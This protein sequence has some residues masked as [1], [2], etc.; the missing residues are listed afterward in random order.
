[1]LTY[2]FRRVSHGKRQHVLLMNTCLSS[3][4]QGI[5]RS[6]WQRAC[7]IKMHERVRKYVERLGKDAGSAAGSSDV[8]ALSDTEAMPGGV[9]DTEGPNRQGSGGGGGR[10][11]ARASEA[12]GTRRRTR[13]AAG[14]PDPEDT[15]GKGGWNPKRDA[16]RRSQGSDPV[17]GAGQEEG[18]ETGRRLDHRH[19]SERAQGF[20]SREGLGEPD[21]A[22]SSKEEGDG[23]AAEETDSEMCAPPA[24]KDRRRG[25]AA[26]RAGGGDGAGAGAQ[27]RGVTKDG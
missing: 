19:G 24:R 10:G 8:G 4:L 26:D 11:E 3:L 18:L 1:M 14:E 22:R 6:I 13:R 5:M 17:Q 15:V 23:S 27:H 21:L 2:K 12:N 25:A 16:A 20:E 9:T 7:R